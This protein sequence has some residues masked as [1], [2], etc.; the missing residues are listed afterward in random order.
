MSIKWNQFSTPLLVLIEIDWSSVKY[1]NCKLHCLCSNTQPESPQLPVCNLL[2]A[3]G[4]KYTYHVPDPALIL[5]RLY[6]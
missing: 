6:S 4:D 2:V 1:K 3:F 5:I